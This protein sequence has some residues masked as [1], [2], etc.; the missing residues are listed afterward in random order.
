MRR[1]DTGDRY[2]PPEPGPR[3]PGRVPHLVLAA[4]LM[5]SLHVF[6]LIWLSPTRAEP[7][8]PASHR[9]R[10]HVL[11]MQEGGAE[12]GSRIWSPVLM[13][14]PTPAGFSGAAMEEK[15]GVGPRVASPR[16][17]VRYLAWADAARPPASAGS[18][19]G[20]GSGLGSLPASWGEGPAPV[21]PVPEALPPRRA[22]PGLH[23]RFPGA[24][25]TNAFEHLVLP[26]L[27]GEPQ[28]WTC[29]VSL[30]F[31]DGGAVTRAFIEEPSG[32]ARRDR[33]IVR[34]VY[35]WRLAADQATERAEVRFT[36]V[37]PLRDPAPRPREGAP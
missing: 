30:W 5:G 7:G 37:A 13:A 33:D 27:A 17:P 15:T 16:G 9:P 35:R 36:R 14:L 28:A 8:H 21:T 4:L 1:M 20:A 32:D 34:A 2:A 3:P 25:T 31:D 19:A 11:P 6:W 29:R 10:L 23:V 24:L 18:P 12:P 26:P 22:P